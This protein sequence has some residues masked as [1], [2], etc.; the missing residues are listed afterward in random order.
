MAHEPWNPL[1][2]AMRLLSYLAMYEAIKVLV[3][4]GPR[5][6]SLVDFQQHLLISLRPHITVPIMV[7]KDKT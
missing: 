4:H 3:A 5:S 6:V 7:F 1:W 2:M